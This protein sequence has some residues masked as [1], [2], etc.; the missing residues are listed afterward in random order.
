MNTNHM[1]QT[2]Q[3]RRFAPLLPGRCFITFR[4][5]AMWALSVSHLP[6][7]SRQTDL[8]SAHRTTVIHQNDP[9]KLARYLFRDGG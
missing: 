8:H 6:Q 2:I 4:I 9:S 3:E 7:S 1:Q 5:Q